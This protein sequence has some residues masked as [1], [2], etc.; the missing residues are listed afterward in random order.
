[1]DARCHG[2]STVAG[3]AWLLIGGHSSAQPCE[4]RWSDE[5]APSE[6]DR[7]VWDLA[8]FDDGLG[9]GSWKCISQT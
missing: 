4:P 5:F 3:L 6:V 8:V 1:M 2:F 7:F 9:R